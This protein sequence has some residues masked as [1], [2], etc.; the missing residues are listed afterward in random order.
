M[1]EGRDSMC[2]VSSLTYP[3]VQGVYC[4]IVKAETLLHSHCALYCKSKNNLHVA[5]MNQCQNSSKDDN[6]SNS[7]HKIMK[8]QS[9][10][11]QIKRLPQSEIPKAY[12]T[13]AYSPRK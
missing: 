2:T 13:S 11:V 4:I 8:S 7:L 12:C 1:L 6:E 5:N 9:E 3:Y 10:N